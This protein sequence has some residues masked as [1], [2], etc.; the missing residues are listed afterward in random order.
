LFLVD[1]SVWAALAAPEDEGYPAATKLI[2][3][4]AS[5][6]A[7]D[8]TLFEVANAV[9]VKMRKPARSRRLFDF[10]VRRSE[11]LVRVDPE[12][13]AA[14]VEAAGKFSLTASDAAYV[15][16]SRRY[17][18]TLVSADIADLVS[19]GLAVTPDAALY[20]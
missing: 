16:V 4:T 1:A 17:D 3:S 9:G 11:E 18:W 7:L 5:V 14:A 10:I 12:V 6:A 13:C 2:E 8:L 15:A 19:K 20:P